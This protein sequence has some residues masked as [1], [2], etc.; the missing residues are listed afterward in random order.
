MIVLV[1]RSFHYFRAIIFIPPTHH[2]VFKAHVNRL[3]TLDSH[4]ESR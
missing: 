2:D 4:G 1:D 3:L